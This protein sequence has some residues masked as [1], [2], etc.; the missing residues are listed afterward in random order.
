[1]QLKTRKLLFMCEHC[2]QGL[3]VLPSLINQV[4][5]LSKQIEQIRKNPV[6]TPQWNK[7]EDQI[8]EIMERNKRRKNVIVFN[9]RESHKQDKNDR[10][11][12]DKN[13]IVKI[14]TYDGSFHLNVFLLFV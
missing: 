8:H 6:S 3:R 2:E 14:L 7:K 11:A 9:V 5:D 4:T 10:N 1:M 13:A 12:E